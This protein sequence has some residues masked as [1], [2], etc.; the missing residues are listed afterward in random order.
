MSLVAVPD[1]GTLDNDVIDTKLAE[2]LA[3]LQTLFPNINF[4]AGVFRELIVNPHAIL[5]ASL[6]AVV[7][8]YE[9]NMAPAEVLADPDAAPAWALE[10][11][12]ARWRLERDPATAARGSIAIVRSVETTLTLP[13]AFVFT[14]NGVGFV[15][16]SVY[17]IKTDEE[18]IE[19]TTDILAQKVSDGR[20]LA[21]IPVVAQDAG[22]T[23][24]LKLGAPVVPEQTIENLITSYAASDF[25]GGSDADTGAELLA[26]LALAAAAPCLSGPT[27]MKAWLLKF[28][29]VAVNSSVVG[30]YFAEMLRDR[31][32]IWPTG[33]GGKVDWYVRTQRE[34]QDLSVTLSATLLEK[35]SDGSGTWQLS[36]S[37]D[38][39]SGFF[40]IISILPE[41][42]EDA[43]S[44]PITSDVRSY[45]VTEDEDAP[46]IESALEAV[47]SSFQTGIIQFHDTTTDTSSLTVGATASYDVVARIMPIIKNIQDAILA[48]TSRPAAG[49]IL[50]K[51]PVPAFTTVDARIT[52]N[53]SSEVTLGA[54]QQAAADAVNMESFSGKLHVSRLHK[55]IQTL[56]GEDGDIEFL[57]VRARIRRPDGTHISLAERDLL[58]VPD[59]PEN[60][61]T[62]N[63]VQFM[64][65]AA[66]ISI[67]LVRIS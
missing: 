65:K 66:D 20:W 49:D 33:G 23:G 2:S 13:T 4:T 40:E 34:Y 1:L 55:A 11:V 61:V 28:F 10:S 58:L 30:A 18:A 22:V 57:T 16:E 21:F 39:A 36:L 29:P 14:A 31:H 59:E 54:L 17:S 53:L 9:S 45:D 7:D 25:V 56:L 51:A 63:T 67:E 19:S 3:R 6:Q 42:S 47:Y 24:L 52:L 44:F 32:W 50:V 15:T 35:F 12:L 60:M 5:E 8:E 37:R 27:N 38:T 41:G 62:A 46:E 26:K 43:G 48:D 64:A